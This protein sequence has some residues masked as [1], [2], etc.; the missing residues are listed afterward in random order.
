MGKEV[1]GECG[2]HSPNEVVDRKTCLDKVRLF[3]EGFVCL[4]GGGSRGHG[5]VALCVALVI[6]KF[7]L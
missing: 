5:K 3:C 1:T 4:W 7:T 2:T 6:L